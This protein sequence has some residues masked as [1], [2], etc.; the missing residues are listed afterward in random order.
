MQSLANLQ[1]LSSFNKRHAPISSWGWGGLPTDSLYAIHLFNWN[2]NDSSGNGRDMTNTWCTFT[3]LGG[4]TS[5]CVVY[6]SST[7]SLTPTISERS[8][9]SAGYIAFSIRF[10]ATFASGNADAV[11]FNIASGGKVGTNAGDFYLWFIAS[12]WKLQRNNEGV[13]PVNLDSVQSSW[14]WGQRYH[15]V[16]AWDSWGRKIYVNWVLNASDSTAVTM[17][18]TNQS[19]SGFGDWNHDTSQTTYIGERY[20]HN[21]A[22]TAGDIAAYYARAQ[23]VY[24][25]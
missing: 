22:V 6:N 2:A 25:F 24:G 18:N 23:E 4:D 10:A 8:N 1:N 21:D 19:T 12:T 20:V 7:D 15:M 14:T 3:T 9:Q 17:W 11:W 5:Q 16:L 13:S